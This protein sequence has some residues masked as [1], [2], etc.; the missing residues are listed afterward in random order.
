MDNNKKTGVSDPDGFA[1]WMT[2]EGPVS[3]LNNVRNILCMNKDP[4]VRDALKADPA[5]A[6]LW[7]SV[8]QAMDKYTQ[9]IKT[10]VPASKTQVCDPASLMGE[11][12][13]LDGQIDMLAILPDASKEEARKWLATHLAIVATNAKDMPNKDERAQVAKRVREVMKKAGL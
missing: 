8:G 2:R 4:Q 11:L 1:K 13:K 12:A 10:R 3:G 7:A 5:I 9:A 6:E